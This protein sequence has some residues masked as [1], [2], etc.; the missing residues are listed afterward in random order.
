MSSGTSGQ[1]AFGL[2]RKKKS[3]GVL[4]QIG[5]FFGGD[6]KKKGKG[7]FRGLSSSPQ[8]PAASR[9]RRGDENAV[10][11]FFRTI[12]SP[13]PPK[14]RWR[15]LSAKLGLA[16]QKKG[17]AGDGQGT[18]TKIFKMSGSRSASPAKR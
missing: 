15:G 11:H 10:V 16:D 6:K 7:S 17:R 2:G 8:R 9:S 18:L 5:K 14:S 3:P 1:A 13:A 12:V 4:D